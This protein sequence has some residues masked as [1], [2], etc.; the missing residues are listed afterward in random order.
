M[1]RVLASIVVPG[2]PAEA[3]DLW[4]DR[5]RWPAFID[6][7]AHVVKLEG[8]WPHPGAELTW[9]SRPGGRGRV[10]ERV[11]TYVPRIGQAVQIE[12]ETMTGTQEVAFAPEGQADTRVTLT[13]DFETKRR[14]P[15]GPLTGFFVR[16]SLTDSLQRT[17]RRFLAEREGDLRL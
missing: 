14:S 9:Q 7:F 2:T 6:G 15:L 1:A 11:T 5:R 4:Y 8:D 3:E 10:R 12:D 17:L 13:L 16:R